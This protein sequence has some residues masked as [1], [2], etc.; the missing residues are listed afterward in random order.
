MHMTI[1]PDNRKEEIFEKNNI[2]IEN[3]IEELD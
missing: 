1:Y 2:E 3:A